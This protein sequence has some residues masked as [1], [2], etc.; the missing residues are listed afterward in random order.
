M[1][2][3]YH[4]YVSV[5]YS[6]LEWGKRHIYNIAYRLYLFALCIERVPPELDS[7]QITWLPALY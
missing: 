7:S 4:F 3:G 5:T 1:Q 2:R 6:I